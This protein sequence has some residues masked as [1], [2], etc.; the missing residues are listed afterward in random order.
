MNKCCFDSL[1]H[2]NDLNLAVNFQKIKDLGFPYQKS[3]VGATGKTFL[4]KD[5]SLC[6]VVKWQKKLFC[7]CEHTC[8]KFYK[9][10]FAHLSV[11]KTFHETDRKT[12][13]VALNFFQKYSGCASLEKSDYPLFMEYLTGNNLVQFGVNKNL[14]FFLEKSI[15]TLFY[16]FGEIAGYD[17]LVGNSDR[18]FPAKFIGNIDTDFKVNGGN[19]MIEVNFDH[20]LKNIHIIDNAPKFSEFFTMSERTGKSDNEPIFDIFSDNVG[21]LLETDE[22]SEVE[23]FDYRADRER[24]FQYYIQGTD[25]EIKK[26]AEQIYIGIKNEIRSSLEN[27]EENDLFFKKNENLIKAKLYE[28]LIKARQNMG[29]SSVSGIFDEIMK[30]DIK[31]EG[32]MI[33]INFV[34]ENLLYASKL[35]NNEK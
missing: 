19:I 8:T 26:M 21:S 15:E 17:L 5:H 29:E 23:E 11:P 24:D 16:S 20:S 1:P 28:G 31:E 34:K 32:T 35:M 22:S 12:R 6:Y 25:E 2:R 14:V 3:T 27:P 30:S 18:F 13:E 9:K 4:P 7:E 10:V 33:F